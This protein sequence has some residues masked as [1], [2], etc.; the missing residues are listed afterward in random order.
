MGKI[1]LTGKVAIV[2]GASGG[3]GK[4]I[5]ISLA[6][7]GAS[8]AVHFGRNKNAADEVVDKIV[9]AKGKAIAVSADMAD[10]AA[11]EEMFR[12]VD[13]S[14]GTV[15]IL[16]NSAGIDGVRA[17]LGDDDIENWKKV[18]SV[19][20][21]G[22]YFCSRMAIQ[23]MKKK[24]KGVIINIT[25]DHVNIPWQ[26]YSAYCSS[27]AGLDM[28]AKT[29]AQET[30]TMGIRVISIA[31]GAIKTAINKS[32]WENP[33]T[34]KD[35]DEKI[36]MGFPGDAEDVADAVLFAASDMAKYITGTTIVVDGGMLIYPD[37]RHGG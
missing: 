7:A 27:K 5:A 21:Y 13:S 23:R 25:S 14:L 2:T 9:A 35:L 31:P 4:A 18:I 11:V 16:V 24:N 15:D 26:G 19:N 22:P 33:D 12:K 3:I 30:A 6:S 8:V 10:P 37:F 32:V 1:D 20:L 28:M 34:L 17:M 29:L 36:A